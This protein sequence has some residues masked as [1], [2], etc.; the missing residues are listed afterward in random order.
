MLSAIVLAVCAGILLLAGGYLL[1]VRRGLQARD[2]L[3]EQASQLAEEVARLRQRGERRD[4]DE[5]LRATIRGVLTPLVQREQLTSDLARLD[6]GDGTN[7]DLTAL[8]DQLVS[9]ANFFGALLSDDQGWPMAASTGLRDSDRLGATTS[10][11]RLL[12]DRMARDGGTAPLAL[13]V[14]DNANMTT[15]CRL[16]TVGSQRLSLTVVSAGRVLTPS[17]L[18]PALSKLNG[19][20]MQ[21]D[22]TVANDAPS[23]AAAIELPLAGKVD[24]AP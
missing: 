12:A 2:A 10:L 20:L 3:R 17:A 6:A 22:P 16:F 1:G 11:L 18:D 23:P 13:M 7:R 19:L 14:Y 21:R 9:K 15:L 24:A 8:L 4:D 5:S